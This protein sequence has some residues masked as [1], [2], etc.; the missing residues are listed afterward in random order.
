[1]RLD[2]SGDGVIRQIKTREVFASPEAND[3]IW[4]YANECSIPGIARINPQADMYDA[5][6][7][8]GMLV[9][10]GAFDGEA[11][12]G[13]ATLM[14][15]VLPHYG[16][17]TATLES[18][19]VAGRSRKKGFGAR[20]LAAVEEYAISKDCEAILYSA[21]AG[22]QLEQ[23]LSARKSCIKTNTIFCNSL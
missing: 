8:T 14:I 1:M 5:M 10:L 17:R 18:L 23:V 13:F 2:L 22:G 19:F 20:L 12:V 15:A 3:L 4:E 21:P 6:E 9:C 16:V 11:L 7:A